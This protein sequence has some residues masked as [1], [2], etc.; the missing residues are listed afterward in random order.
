[1]ANAR[2]A[3]VEPDPRHDRFDRPSARY[4]R[5]AFATAAAMRSRYSFRGKQCSRAA[6]TASRVRN[7]RPGVLLPW[8]S[9]N[10]ATTRRVIAFKRQTSGVM[11]AAG[12]VR[13]LATG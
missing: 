5:Y 8:H 7:R 12:P 2:I 3:I 10:A 11:M 6:A 1:M 9:S 13:L 4:R